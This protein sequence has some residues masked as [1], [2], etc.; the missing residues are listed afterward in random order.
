MRTSRFSVGL[1][2]VFVFAML[3]AVLLT[4]C[5]YPRRETIMH[6]APPNLVKADDRPKQMYTIRV[7]DAEIPEAKAGGLPWDSDGTEP[8]PFVRIYVGNRKIWESPVQMNT[9]KP[10]WNITLPR[11]V[12]IPDNTPF[13]LEIW[14][15][16]TAVSEDPAGRIERDGL[17]E[18]ALPDAIARLTLDNLGTLSIVASAPHAQQGVGL[19]FEVRPDALVVLDVERYSPAFRAGIL[20][21]DRIVAIGPQRVSELSGGEAASDLSLANDKGSTLTIADQKGQERQVTLDKGFI[22]LVM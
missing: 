10:S 5:A 15:R 17:P 8:D 16:D 4:G 2:S 3:F 22:W 20:K 13:R 6:A 1:V 21:G 19:R 12:E 7:L 9:R 11:N 14:D 18:T